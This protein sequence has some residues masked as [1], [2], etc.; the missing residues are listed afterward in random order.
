MDRN[1]EMFMLIEKSLVTNECLK[2]PAI[3][4]RPDVDKIYASKLK[5]NTNWCRVPGTSVSRACSLEYH[6]DAYVGA[7]LGPTCR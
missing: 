7:P 1:V 5:V 4:L 2:R 3:F 6:G